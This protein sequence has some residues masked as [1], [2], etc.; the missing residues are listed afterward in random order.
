MLY[1][2]G[3]ISYE[4]NDGNQMYLEDEVPPDKPFNNIPTY[5]YDRNITTCN[6]IVNSAYFTNAST[7]SPLVTFDS[8]SFQLY[9]DACVTGSLTVL[10][11]TS[12][13][14]NATKPRLLKLTLLW[15]KLLLLDK[16]KQPTLFR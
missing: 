8:D 6:P 16:E 13:L 15:E 14:E 12:F 9:I 11:P 1:Q 2:K 4:V 7:P 10:L 5:C 3:S